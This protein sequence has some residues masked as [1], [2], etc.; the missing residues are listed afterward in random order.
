MTNESAITVQREIPASSK[1]I[2]DVVTLPARHPELDASGFV[3]SDDR[4]DRITEVGQTFR[5]NMSGDH[6]GGEY[7]TDNLVTGYDPDK[8]VAWKTAPAG[9]EPPGWEWRWELKAQGPDST[10]VTLTYDWSKVEPEFLKKIS[11][12][13]VPKA[14]LEESLGLLA[15][16]VS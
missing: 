13:L 15:S 3:R 7:Q 4:T 10:E 2:F 14:A 5:M 9:Q 12:P 11:F 1:A 16:A 8:L 6:M